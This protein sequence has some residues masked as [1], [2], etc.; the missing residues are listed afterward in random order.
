MDSEKKERKFLSHLYNPVTY[1][2]L[3]LFLT[4]F[5]IEWFFFG[6]DFLSS[7]SN[8]YLGLFTYIILPPF[9]FLG[10]IL[11]P[12]GAFW[13]RRRIKKGR[14][15]S[16]LKIDLSIPAH[17]N[18]LFVFL[19][20]V[21]I[22]ALMSLV[23]TYK[24]YQYSESVEFCGTLCHSVMRPEYTT[25]LKSPHGRLKCVECHIGPGADWYVKSKLSGTR[26]IL[27]TIFNTYER[28]IRTPVRDLRP[29]EATCKQCHWPGKY[30]G[31]M[32]FKRM[33]YPSDGTRPAWF[34]RMLLNVGGG[35]TQTYGIHAHMNLDR[36]IYYAAEDEKRQL[37]T[38]VK[39][40]DKNGRERI[41][42]SKDSK[43]QSVAPPADVIRK[44]DCIDCHNRPSHQFLSPPR[45]IND[46]L[47]YGTI[48]NA[49]P[50]IKEKALEVLSR[51]YSTT[52]EA[53]NSIDKEL[54]DYYLAKQN[55]YYRAHQSTV[56]SAI[57]RVIELYTENMFPEMKAR[58]T[59]HPDNIGHM[60]APGCFR[61][62]DSQHRTSQGQIISQ[63]C[64]S[65]HLIVEQ[66][67]V[68]RTEKTIDGLPFR[69]PVDIGQAWKESLCY[70]C[71]SA[72]R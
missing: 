66:G 71:H 5:F 8:L 72:D 16:W 50:G 54:H 43:W 69:H 65:C 14:S 31:T 22:F 42:V 24:G 3:F 68:G 70:E 51:Q 39:A 21:F 27:R 37:I 64:N 44:M 40:V 62:H 2:G 67:P 32:D 1:C 18:T 61:C 63:D 20:A 41:F 12:L 38:W 57:K 11:I 52:K 6:I 19:T 33:Y 48:D 26:Q 23:G 34:V 9:L 59:T 30:F 46:A 49:V 36:D 60:L 58:W 28:P 7:R 13:Y 53:V 55:A 45:L 29:A 56:D 25:Y 15:A 10:L 17:R 35:N 47:Q 4:V